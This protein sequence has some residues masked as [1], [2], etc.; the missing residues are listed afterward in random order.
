VPE[1]PTLSGRGMALMVLLLLGIAAVY[2]V[3]QRS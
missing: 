1:I 3:R 2:L